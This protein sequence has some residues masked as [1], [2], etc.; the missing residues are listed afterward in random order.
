MAAVTARLMAAAAR[1]CGWGVSG[2]G[3]VNGDQDV[4]VLDVVGVVEHI[5]NGGGRCR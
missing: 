4:N 2:A 3:D 5:I 1:Y